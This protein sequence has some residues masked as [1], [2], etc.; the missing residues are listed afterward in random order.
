MYKKLLLTVTVLIMTQ[1]NLQAQVDQ[2]IN[3]QGF[4]TDETG[5]QVED[6]TFIFTFSIYDSETGGSSLWTENQVLQVTNGVFNAQLGSEE[7]LDLAFDG[8]YWIG[9]EIDGGGEMEPRMPLSAAPYAMHALTVKDGAITTG[10]IEDGAVTMAKLAST[11]N[12]VTN[13]IGS[14]S[15]LT[16]SP[17]NLGS[18]T[19]EASS[20]GSVLLFLS[21]HAVFFGDNTVLDV[22]F[23]NSQ[24]SYDIYKTR[25]GRLDGAQTA[26]YNQAVNPIGSV[27]VKE[28][29]HT[30][31][32]TAE[33]SSVFDS[34]G[35]NLSSLQLIA[36]FLP[37]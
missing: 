33:K 18:V 35:I 28:G 32:A 23:G 29:T 8:Q 12:V 9:V 31:Y 13:T 17:T 30:F 11:A 27:E 21:G 36:V 19:V 2:I 3:H 15:D 37:K 6:D 16:T 26:R 7:P 1:L 34:N 20:S 10:K 25:R 14:H 24:G 5:Q 4:L 22:G